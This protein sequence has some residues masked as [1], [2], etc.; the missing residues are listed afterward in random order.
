MSPETKKQL[1]SAAI[2]LVVGMGSTYAM[3][4]RDVAV[5]KVRLDSMA[6]D[7]RVI[8]M[9]ISNDDPRAFIAA[10]NQIKKDAQKASE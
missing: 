6:G 7:I 10:K 1:V 3:V 8:Q 5:I 9:F 4:W 2:G